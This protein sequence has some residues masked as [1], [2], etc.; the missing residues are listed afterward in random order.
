[1]RSLSE[2]EFHK[3]NIKQEV[4]LPAR[5]MKPEN[6]FFVHQRNFAEKSKDVVVLNL[7]IISA[8]TII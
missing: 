1:M 3:S 7:K 5:K 8:F 6:V 4:Y 2:L